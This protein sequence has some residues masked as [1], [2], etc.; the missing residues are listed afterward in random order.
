MTHD[1]RLTLIMAP[2]PVTRVHTYS[3][4][5]ACVGIEWPEDYEMLITWAVEYGLPHHTSFQVISAENI[6]AFLDTL[7][8][9][10][11]DIP[12]IE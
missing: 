9:D 5:W 11:Y 10:E 3:K 2:L 6:D 12:E 7:E 4:R 8:E 1:E